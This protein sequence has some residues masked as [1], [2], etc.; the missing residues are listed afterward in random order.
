MSMLFYLCRSTQKQIHLTEPDSHPLSVSR[1][2]RLGKQPHRIAGISFES[3]IHLKGLSIQ[4]IFAMSR[5]L[6]RIAISLTKI[7]IAEFK[8]SKKN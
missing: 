3:C 8:T 5:F 7:Q 6:L 2:D 1:S 4:T